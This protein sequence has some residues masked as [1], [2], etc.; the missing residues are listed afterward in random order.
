MTATLAILCAAALVAGF[1]DAVGGGGGL[2]TLPALLWGGLPPHA[3]LAT[4]KG[5]SVFGAGMSLWRYARGRQFDRIEAR[6]L[7]LPFGCGAVGAA[8]GAA[9]ALVIDPSALRPV[10]LG[11]LLVAGL[12]VV[13]LTHTASGN[14][15]RGGGAGTEDA[16]DAAADAAA[17]AANLRS[18]SPSRV[19]EVALPGCAGLYD[20]FFGPGTG[21]F[22]LLAYVGVAHA[23]FVQ[24][25]ARAKVVNFATNLAAVAW[26]AWHGQVLWHLALPMAAAQAA[27]AYLGVAWV[28]RGGDA[29]VRLV[30]LGV[31]G[32]LTLR[33]ISYIS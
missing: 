1:V 30:V 5:Q 24:A 27:G 4:N 14:A 6:R 17:T 19:L 20:G 16:A 2:V 13:W 21:T 23:G 12:A 28:L 26:F 11:L 31:M 32:L 29:R 18:A 3:A 7:W 15:K 25:S 10:L 33:L 9:A 22:L 8:V